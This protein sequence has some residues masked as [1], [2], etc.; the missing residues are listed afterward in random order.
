MSSF[1]QEKVHQELWRIFG[2]SDRPATSRDLREMEQ[3][4]LCIK[5]ALRMFPVAP[6]I[7]RRLTG[8]VT[9]CKYPGDCA[10]A[11]STW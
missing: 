4:E 6:I 8:D 10:L 9:L 7:A 3:L 1:C 11:A 2:A 5:E